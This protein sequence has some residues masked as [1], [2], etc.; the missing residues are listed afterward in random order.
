[1]ITYP[2]MPPIRY[3]LSGPSPSRGGGTKAVCSRNTSPLLTGEV[4]E[5]CK[6]GG[7]GMDR[8]ETKVENYIP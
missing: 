4:G 3:P 6:P 8:L 7:G 1:M 2:G 5:H